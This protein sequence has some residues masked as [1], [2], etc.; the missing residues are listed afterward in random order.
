MKPEKFT[1]DRSKVVHDTIEGETI[2]IN[3]D[4]GAYYALNQTAGEVWNWLDGGADIP[5]IVALLRQRYTVDEP[6]A[7]SAL[8]PFFDKLVLE[9]L[10]LAN[11]EAVAAAGGNGFQEQASHGERQPF[12]P[13]E[14]SVFTDMADFLK[15]DPIHEVDEK[16][17]PHKK[18]SQDGEA[19]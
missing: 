17:W 14:V 15:V 6:N 7:L 8:A 12:L 3:L 13:P 4:S 1:V 5:R 9:G 10:L 16:G 18:A 11:T 2:I 19:H